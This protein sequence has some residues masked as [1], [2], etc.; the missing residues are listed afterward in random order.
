V[1]GAALEFNDTNFETEVIKSNVPVLVDFWA[2]WCGPCKMLGPT[3][4]KIAGDSE[5]S[6]KVKVGKLNVDDSPNSAS[7][8]G[9]QA[10]PTM[11]FF[12]GGQVVDRVVGVVS[13]KDIR[14]KLEK[15]Y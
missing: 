12:K 9:I 11:L 2:V 8:F 6:G 5:L 14:E 4:E 1:A 10:I 3:I 15:L 7:K 13:E